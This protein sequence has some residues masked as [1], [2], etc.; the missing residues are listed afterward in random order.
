M[1]AVEVRGMR[2]RFGTIVAL[3]SIDLHVRRK[4][5]TA[6]LGPNGAGKT[7][8][9]RILTTRLRPD[10]GGG[11]VAGVD[12]TMSAAQVRRRI[13]VVAQ[14]AAVDD[15]LTARETLVLVGRLRHMRRAAARTEADRLIDRFALEDVAAR[16]AGTYS[17][18]TR[19][20]LDLAAAVVG[21]PEV[22]FLDEPTTG[23][24]PL[25]RRRLWDLVRALAAE[26]TAVV[27]TTQYLEEADALAGDIHLIVGGR[28][29][30]SGTGPELKAQVGDAT[31]ELSFATK[32]RAQAA[33]RSLRAHGLAL[34]P[35]RIAT[36]VLVL[37]TSPSADLLAVL[38]H[39]A[40]ADIRVVDIDIHRPTLDDVLAAHVAHAASAGS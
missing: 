14:V 2:K 25:S 17:G 40:T 22:L 10:G 36:R 32:A 6:V 39:L 15:S 34:A 13:G 7:T 18:G 38:N 11:T 26:G 20:R 27:L 33:T 24:D 8:L 35:T 4:A 5:I 28:V 29:V 23:L 31:L 12:L 37:S 21:S 1:N 30:A 3:Q 9:I 16:P 19:R